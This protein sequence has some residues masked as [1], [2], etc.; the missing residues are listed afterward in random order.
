MTE[1]I[2]L[3]EMVLNKSSAA[4]LNGLI[5]I[6]ANVILE[7]EADNKQ[8]ISDL[9]TPATMDFISHLQQQLGKFGGNAPD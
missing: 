9:R 8:L 4:A 1:K 3:M 2:D 7:V 5:T 6:A